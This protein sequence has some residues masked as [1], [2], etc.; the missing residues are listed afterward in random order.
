MLQICDMGQTALLPLR[1]RHA[2]EFL[3]EKSDGFSQVRTP[4]LG[5]RGRHA[6]HQTTKTTCSRVNL[7]NLY[8]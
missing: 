1:G 5:T 3:P 8:L 6:N 4:I 7:H 2:V